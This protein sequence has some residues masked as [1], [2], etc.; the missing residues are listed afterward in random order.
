MR[1]TQITDSQTHFTDE[2]TKLFK[3]PIV[4]EVHYTDGSKEETRQWIQDKTQ[5]VVVPN[6]SNKQIAYVLFDPAGYIVKKVNFKKS[7]EELKA[8]ALTAEH[9]IDRYD[10]IVALG[11]LASQ[12][13]SGSKVPPSDNMAAAFQSGPGSSS[14]ENKS[15]ADNQNY[16]EKK[17]D[18]LIELYNK[19]KYQATRCEIVTQLSQDNS[20]EARAIIRRAIKDSAIEVRN[21]ILNAYRFIPQDLEPDMTQLLIDS[22]YNMIVNSLDKLCES[23]PQNKSKY[24]EV[25]RDEV[26]PSHKVRIKWLEMKATMGDHKAINELDEYCSIS[27]EFITRQLAMQSLQRL[28]T[29]DE[30]G[31]PNMV[32]AYLSTNNRLAGVAYGILNTF[33]Q[34]TANRDMMMAYYKSKTWEPWQKEILVNVFK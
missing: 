12:T 23:F 29:L 11:S 34:Q 33:Y 8:Q 3:M 6:S 4:F 20:P 25:T 17:R 10:A 31:L 2:L 30:V 1:E 19:E 15:N 27:Y 9:L 5:T 18:L 16:R 22:S 14:S 7:F 13:E 26:G 24:L 21:A 32:D 28:N